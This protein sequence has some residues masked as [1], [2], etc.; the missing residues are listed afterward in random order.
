[1]KRKE[2]VST[3][4]Y[5]VALEHSAIVQYLN[6]IFLIQDAEIREEIEKIARQEMRHMK[7]FAQK[8]VQLGGR[9]ELKRIEEEIDLSG[10]SPAE[11]L[12]KDVKA[13]RHAVEIYTEQLEAV[14]DDSV[15]ALLDRVIK[16]EMEHEDEFTELLEEVNK[17][18]IS[19]DK[20]EADTENTDL[21][22]RFLQDEYSLI[23]DCLQKLFHSKN[24]EYRDIML[25][26]AIE[27]MVHMGELGEL[28]GKRGGTPDLS[29][30]EPKGVD[31]LANG[32]ESIG[33]RYIRRAEGGPEEIKKLLSWIGNQKKYHRYKLLEFFRGTKKLTVGDLRS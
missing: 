24:C 29:M 17:K 30:P 26:I 18:E 31:K 15:R 9:V 23:L 8:A 27:S 13:E 28:I 25:D 4:L 21:L 16:D 7:W 5:N 22:N 19:Q 20:I 14:K 12:E 10:S 2:L 33:E 32:G 3:L 6:H 1:M 11:M